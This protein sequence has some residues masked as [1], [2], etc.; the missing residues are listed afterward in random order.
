MRCCADLLWP[1]C[2]K[3][4]NLGA[5]C[6]LQGCHTAL[7]RVLS[8]RVRR[9]AT[10]SSSAVISNLTCLHTAH[11]VGR[12]VTFFADAPHY[13]QRQGPCRGLVLSSSFLGQSWKHADHGCCSQQQKQSSRPRGGPRRVTAMAAKGRHCTATAAYERLLLSLWLVHLL[14]LGL[15]VAQ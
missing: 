3:Q 10:H 2:C 14:M 8:V 4:P 12:T 6:H 1:R 5:R 11:L 9:P 7:R 15:L 13:L